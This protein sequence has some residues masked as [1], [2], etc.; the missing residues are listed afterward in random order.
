MKLPCMFLFFNYWKSDK[1]RINFLLRV[2]L[3]N[4]HSSIFTCLLDSRK[5]IT[6]LVQYSTV[7]HRNEC[8]LFNTT[9]FERSAHI[10]QKKGVLK[11]II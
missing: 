1:Y 10:I 5:Y 2:F 7:L 8:I 6:A 3:C 9:A 11:V 4:T